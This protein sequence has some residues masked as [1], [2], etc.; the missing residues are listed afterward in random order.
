MRLLLAEDE[1]DLSEALTAIFEHNHY[2]VDAVYNG[3][4][5]LDYILV[6]D[7]DGVVL[8]VM[9]PGMDGFEVLRK[10]R[11]QKNDVPILML[12]AKADIDDRVFGLDNGA[13]DYLGKPFAAKE[14]LAR[15]RAITRRKTEA[16]D[17]KITVGNLVLDDAT[18][19]LKGP[20]DEIRLPNKEFQMLEMLMSN[21]KQIISADRF[22]DNAVKY[23]TEGSEIHVSLE[24]KGRKLIYQISNET[25]QI[26]KGNQDVLFERFYRSD[27]SRNSATGGSGIGLSVAKAVAEAHHGK[28]T[29]ESKDGKSLTIT[30]TVGP[31]A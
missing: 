18:G 19:I 26:A 2:E 21:P 23:S 9:M 15:V 30:L 6:G 5:A 8:D 13:D 17:A 10:V 1:K 12:T 25:D 24:R 29:A 28:L 22:L 20:K 3:N 31:A 11:E 7:Y 27:A 4:D 14:L 16:L